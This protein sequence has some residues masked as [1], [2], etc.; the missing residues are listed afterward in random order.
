MK[1]S[2]YTFMRNGIYFDY[3]IVHMLKH[4]LPLADEIIVNEGYSSDDTYNRIKNIEKKIKI[5]RENWDV[6]KGMTIYA[7]FKE[8]ARKKCRG[9]WCI[10]LDSDEF[11]PEWEFKNIREYLENSENDI[12]PLRYTNFYGNYKVYNKYPEKFNWPVF[13]HTIHRNL[14]DMEVWGDGSNVR[15]KGSAPV[16]HHDKY[17]DCHHFGAV[18]N[19]ARLRQKWHMHLKLSDT[20][21]PRW[22]RTPGFL[23][24][25][26]PYDWF[27]KDFLEYLAIYNGPFIKAVREDPDEFVRD[28]YVLYNFLLEKNRLYHRPD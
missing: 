15:L 4:H 19:A 1:I 21:N 6:Q 14:N 11:I 28:N 20:K 25:L 7:R 18:R 13:K 10:L 27:D 22:D 9:E 2:I 26:M 3:H 24:D 16:S 23:F 8:S 17:F 12:I 5:F